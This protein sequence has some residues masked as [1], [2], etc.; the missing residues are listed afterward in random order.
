M[1]TINNFPSN[2]LNSY[3]RVLYN[4]KVL[5]IPFWRFKTDWVKSQASWRFQISERLRL[6]KLALSLHSEWF[7]PNL[8][9]VI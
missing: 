3:A 9:M 5:V 1:V 2:P 6:Q 8:Q 7:K 4:D